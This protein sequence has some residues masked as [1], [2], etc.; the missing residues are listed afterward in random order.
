[1]GQYLPYMKYKGQK[2]NQL[3]WSAESTAYIPEYTPLHL[4]ALNGHFSTCKLIIENVVEKN[5]PNSALFTP[6]HV[7][8][9]SGN[10]SIFEI[11]IEDIQGNKNPRDNFGNTPLHIVA[12]HGKVMVLWFLG[13]QMK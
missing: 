2:P 13:W 7:A 3:H 10:D 11:I 4:A 1:M 6:L 8:A 9:A 12:G 5:P